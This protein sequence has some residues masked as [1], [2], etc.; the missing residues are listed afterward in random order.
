M[1]KVSD[2]REFSCNSRPHMVFKN[3]LRIGW[4]IVS[5]S[6]AVSSKQNFYWFAWFLESTKF[7]FLIITSKRIKLQSCAKSQIAGNSLAIPDLIWF[8]KLGWDN[9]DKRQAW[10]SPIPFFS[11]DFLRL[12]IFLFFKKNRRTEDQNKSFAIDTRA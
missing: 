12:T 6:W 10:N 11:L 8:L 7:I 4:D 2:C 3:W 1:C 5:G 9:G